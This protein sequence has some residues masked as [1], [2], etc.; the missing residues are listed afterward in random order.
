MTIGKKDICVIN[1]HYAIVTVSSFKT[2]IRAMLLSDIV[3]SKKQFLNE[4]MERKNEKILS[5]L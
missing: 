2:I 1:E 5:I 3:S 4:K